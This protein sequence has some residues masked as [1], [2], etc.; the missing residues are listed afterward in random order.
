MS[1]V[2]NL[3]PAEALVV[4]RSEE[5]FWL[6]SGLSFYILIVV[7]QIVSECY[8]CQAEAVKVCSYSCHVCT[9]PSLFS[10]DLS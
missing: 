2:E 7:S 5:H 1:S 10:D 6:S 3:L 4:G 8:D 9:Y